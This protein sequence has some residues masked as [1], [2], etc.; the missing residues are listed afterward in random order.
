MCSSLS[1]LLT[2][3]LEVGGFVV[4]RLLIK[5][6]RLA[7]EAGQYQLEKAIAVSCLSFGNTST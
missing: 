7:V 3:P 2:L 4:R 1:T 6:D 5:L